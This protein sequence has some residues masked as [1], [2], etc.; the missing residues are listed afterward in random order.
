M[1]TTTATSIVSNLTTVIATS[2]AVLLLSWQLAAAAFA[3]L[4]VFVLIT[5]R[6]GRLRRALAAT[7][8]S[9][10]ADISSLVEDSLSVVGSAAGKDDGAKR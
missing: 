7:T 2:V 8:Q 1:V 5:R 10:L 4:P 3:L 6:I 9:S